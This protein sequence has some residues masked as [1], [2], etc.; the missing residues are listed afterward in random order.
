MKFFRTLVKAV[1][2][3][4][5]GRRLLV[6]LGGL[7]LFRALAAIPVPGIDPARLDALFS[8]NQFLGVVNLLSGGGLQN[9]S[10][11]LLGVGPYITASIIMQLMTILS[12][13]MKALYQDEGQAGRI[14][15]NQYSRLLTLPL[16]IV[17][18]SAF[19]VF[20][21]SQGVL[22]ALSAFDFGVNLAVIVAGSLLLMWIGELMTEYGI[23]NG[24]SLIIFGGIVA[25]LPSSLGQ[26]L[27]TFTP[28]QLPLYLAFAAIAIITVFLVVHFTEAERTIPISH[29]RDSRGGKVVQ[30]YLPL[31]LNPS[32]VVPIIF[33][34]SILLFPQIAGSVL[35]TLT[36][37]PPVFADIGRGLISFSQNTLAYGIA[38]FFLVFV[39]TYFYTAIVIEPDSIAQN[40]QRSGAFIAG[41]RPG[42]ATATY[43]G[44]VVTRLTFVGALFLALIAVI[45]I[46]AQHITGVTTLAIGGTSLLIAVS[47]I[48]DVVRKIDGQ[49][50][51]REY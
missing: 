19:L 41:V 34:L 26:A 28:A 6:V 46:A 1:T 24:L 9:L 35:T 2:D 22:P 51:L 8:N 32:G 12:P 40:L 47:V 10:I 5:V 31:R 3:P 7:V 43:I 37:L 13:K 30:S 49:L 4:E 25:T 38:Y 14:K 36:F 29:A 20:F 15:F 16:A 50:S 23:G 18:G 11:M 42:D 27:Y 21:E 33:A 17:Q 48:L 44:R 39:F 45:P